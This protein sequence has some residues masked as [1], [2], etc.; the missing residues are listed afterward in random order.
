MSAGKDKKLSFLLEYSQ[1]SNHWALKKQILLVNGQILF[2]RIANHKSHSY[3]WFFGGHFQ[4][5]GKVSSHSFKKN[6]MTLLWIGFNCHK[7][8]QLLRRDRLLLTR[9][10]TGISGIRFTSFTFPRYRKQD[11]A[12]KL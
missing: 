5:V 7:S 12:F 8:L 1:T 9:V 10:F 2:A 6:F 4:L 11:M 3:V